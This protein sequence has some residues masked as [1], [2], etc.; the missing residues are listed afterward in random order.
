MQPDPCPLPTHPHSL[1][2]YVLPRAPHPVQPSS[3]TY[4]LPPPQLQLLPLTSLTAVI[5]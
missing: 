2:A 4:D 5:P 1:L 3:P